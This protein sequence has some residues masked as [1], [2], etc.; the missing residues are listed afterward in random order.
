MMTR[1]ILFALAALVVSGC[2]DTPSGPPCASDEKLGNVNRLGP[3]WTEIA[4][5]QLD[6]TI[7]AG[8]DS[9]ATYRN[10]LTVKHRRKGSD[11][12]RPYR[13]AYVAAFAAAGWSNTAIATDSEAEFSADFRRA[14][15]TLAIAVSIEQ[16]GDVIELDAH[17]AG[18]GWPAVPPEPGSWQE[19]A[20]R[21]K[22]ETIRNVEA[23]IE[24]GKNE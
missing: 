4:L 20:E 17:R 24:R 14:D 15:G 22:E 23:A 8:T 5:P 16:R 13:D 10:W 9:P 3:P 1:S 12:V 7:C 18:P 21:A 19:A 2:D 6:G 11:G